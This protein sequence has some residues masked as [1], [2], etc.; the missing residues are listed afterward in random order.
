MSGHSSGW[1][2][3]YSISAKMEVSNEN[4]YALVTQG[5]K[6][7]GTVSTTDV[8]LEECAEAS[9]A[10]GRQ[11]FSYRS[12]TSKCKIPSNDALKQCVTNVDTTASNSQ[13]WNVYEVNDEI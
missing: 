1:K 8:S 9:Q 6:C 12:S 3:T 4:C 7:K 10:A 2:R 11:F 5:A 13:Y